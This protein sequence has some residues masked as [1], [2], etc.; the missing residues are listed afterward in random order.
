LAVPW[1]LAVLAVIALCNPATGQVFQQSRSVGGIFVDLNGILDI[2]APDDLGKLS[3]LRAD[4]IDEIPAD[5]AGAVQLRKISLRRLEAAIQA[6]PGNDKLLPDELRYLGGLQQIRYVFVYPE[7]GD[8]VLVGPGEG[9]KADARGNVVGVTTG[10]PVMLLEDLLVAL[11]TADQAARGGI[12]CSIDPTQEGLA[13]L[14][15]HVATLRQM[16]NPQT[17]AAGIE[18]ALGPQRISVHGVPATS[19]FARVLVAADY[20]MKR[21]AMKFDPTPIRELPSFLDMIPASG[22][23]MSNM[24]PRWWL[25]P[26]YEPIVKSS[27][28]LAFELRGASVKCMTESD[29]VA[30]TGQKQVGAKASP[31]AQRWADN[32]TEHY[33][34]LA[35]AEPIFGELRNCMELAIVAALITKERLTERAGYSMPLLTDPT[36]LAVIEYPAPGQVDSKVSMVQKRGGWV[37]SASGGVMLNSWQVADRTTQDSAPAEVRT[38]SASTENTNWWWN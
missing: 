32:M 12:S 24:L 15:R 26:N 21:L 10:R 36:D 18:Q 22:R 28:G 11:R 29:F 38:K 2:A 34:E 16:G 37:I 17:T 14:Q 8:I 6:H 23:G 35:V 13:R 27:D 4:G 20:R 3:Q 30:A 25:E 31:M 1:S 19:H 5:L 9:W 33:D 7:Q